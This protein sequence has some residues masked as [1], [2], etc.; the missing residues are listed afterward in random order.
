MCYCAWCQL[1]GFGDKYCEAVLQHL[2]S[3]TQLLNKILIMI[4]G[5]VEVA[6]RNS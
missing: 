4:F 6:H 3:F 2:L 1:L 5:V